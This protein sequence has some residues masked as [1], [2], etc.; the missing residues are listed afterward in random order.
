MII[1]LLKK[2]RHE[3]LVKF[4]DFL[5]SIP[6]FA[7]QKTLSAERQTELREGRLKANPLG[8]ARSLEGI[9]TGSQPSVWKALKHIH[10]PA[11]FICGTLDE[12]SS[13]ISANVCSRS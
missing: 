11:L 2:I 13:A 1:S 6:L 10:L 7:S 9:G 5:E 4:V 8:L 12:K 3:G